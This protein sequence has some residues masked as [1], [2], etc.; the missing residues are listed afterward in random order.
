M[1]SHAAGIASDIKLFNPNGCR[2]KNFTVFVLRAH[3][4]Y[5]SSANTK[6]CKVW[7]S[8]VGNVLIT[9][10]EL[11][12]NRTGTNLNKMSSDLC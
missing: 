11:R 4:Y 12:P 5:T 8:M 7:W 2:K 3:V 9:A 6:R 10:S 1:P